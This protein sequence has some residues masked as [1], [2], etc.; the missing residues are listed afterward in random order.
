MNTNNLSTFHHKKKLKKVCDKYFLPFEI[1]N[2]LDLGWML[3]LVS[4][5]AYASS[6]INIIFI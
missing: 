4:F 3:L 1:W 5:F 2:Y 6:E